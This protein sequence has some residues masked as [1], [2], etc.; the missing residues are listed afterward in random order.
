MQRVI[1]TGRKYSFVLPSVRNQVTRMHADDSVKAEN[2]PEVRSL[3]K[4]ASFSS[5]SPFLCFPLPF[6]FIHLTLPLFF[7]TFVFPLDF[8]YSIFFH[9]LS[10]LAFSIPWIY[11][12]HYVHYPISFIN[13]F[14]AWYQ[15]SLASYVGKI[16]RNGVMLL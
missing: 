9:S 8:L 3:D 7:A 1:K 6:Q 15:L 11:L 12:L 14:Q 4:L 5:F 2:S 16:N 10:H 13:H